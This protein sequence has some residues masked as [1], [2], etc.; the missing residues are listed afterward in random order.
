MTARLTLLYRA[1]HWRKTAETDS[2]QIVGR[3]LFPGLVL[4]EKKDPQKKQRDHYDDE[5]ESSQRNHQYLER[6]LPPV[7]VCHS[8]V[9]VK[10]DFVIV[11][12]L[13]RN[14]IS[15][16]ASWFGA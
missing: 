7:D 9:D 16:G 2:L 3:V 1:A 11:L 8:P 6:Q 13:G 4:A 15:P 5:P 12:R 10:T 14:A